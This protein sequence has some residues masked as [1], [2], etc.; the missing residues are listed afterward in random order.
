MANQNFIVQNGINIGGTSGAVISADPTTGAVVISPA[1]T[2]ATPNPTAVVISTAGTVSTVATTAGVANVAAVSTASNT[3]TATSLTTM[4]NVLITGNLTVNGTAT[5]T[6]TETVLGV[7]V[8][9]GNLVA[10]SGATSTS[11]TTGALVVT[12]GAGISGNLNVGGITTFAGNVNPSANVTYS[13][14]SRT[15][16]WKDLYVGPGTLYINGTP[17]LGA[18]TTG[19]P[20]IN[21]TASAGQ[22][23]AIATNGGG[24]LQLD[25]G[26]AGAGYI[27]V[28]SPLQMAAGYNITSSDG[29]AI[30]FA[31]QI[32][33]DAITSHSSNT[34]LTLTAQG[35]GKVS[36]NSDAVITGNLT[37]NG[38]TEIINTTVLN[39]TTQYATLNSG[40]VGSPTLD[41]GL[42]VN[43]G[44]SNNAVLKWSESAGTWQASSDNTNFYPITNTSSGAGNVTISA[45]GAI[46]LTAT[47]TAQT[48]GSSTAIPVITTD[49]YGRV[50]ALTTATVSIPSGSLTFTGDVTGTGNTGSST[51]LTIA[52]G[53]VTN[54]KL[55]NSSI[56]VNGTAIS[57][58][59]SATITAA[60]GS[61]TGSTLA[62]GVTAS[63]LTSVGTLTGLT[64]SSTITGSV[65]GSAAT[66]T[67]AGT[68]TTAAQPNITSVGTL[69]GL[70]VS[71]TIAASTNNSIN[72]GASGSVFAT[73]YATTF[74]GVST[75]AKY[76]DLA[77][78]YQGDKTYAPGTVVMFGGTQE[79]TVADA[80]T[81]AVAGV[82]ST[83]PAHLMNGGLTGANVVP[84]A[85]Q[86]RVPCMVIGPVKKGDMLVSAGHGYAK[87]S[88]NPQL[89][90]VIGK[91]LYD[92]PGS[93]K[94]VIE[95]VVGRL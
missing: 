26:A 27:Q 77:E 12:G 60:A 22:N 61:L 83:N 18:S 40:V 43:R 45:T 93:S 70:T 28:K 87:S 20:T 73:V 76:A 33:V 2:A 15:L 79:V 30:Q 23:I 82:V 90:Q 34:N 49:A 32:G 80:D 7:E 14:G 38:Q 48:V 64:V 16:M 68:V 57:L 25:G 65:S 69:T 13:L 10:N 52:N 58:G 72:I 62:S 53:A 6:S 56:T 74:S 81:T 55:A 95:V 31:N 84:V 51:A 24:I 92:F 75:T 66:A 78:N 3:A 8:V 39:V 5:Y 86:G 44:T 63:S 67:T 88:A 85:L 17:V 9:A 89:G 1:P 35:T 19:T 36:I 47:G 54:A 59:G 4:A 42:R 46:T 41:A 37:V 21:F 91:A 11:T 94:A 71:G 50:T 29:N